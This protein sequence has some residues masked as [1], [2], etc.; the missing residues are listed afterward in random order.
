M[1]VKDFS[2]NEFNLYRGPFYKRLENLRGL[3]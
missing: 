3:L 1:T 2:N